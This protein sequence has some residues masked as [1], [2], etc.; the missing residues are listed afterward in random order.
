M[1]KKYNFEKQEGEMG[2]RVFQREKNKNMQIQG[3]MNNRNCEL[4]RSQRDSNS[5]LFIDSSNFC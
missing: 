5:N 2:L 3:N 4:L 1:K